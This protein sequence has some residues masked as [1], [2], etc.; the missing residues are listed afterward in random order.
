MSRGVSLRGGSGSRAL[1]AA[2]SAGLSDRE[3]DFEFG[4]ARKRAHAAGDGALQR[5]LRRFLLLAGLRFESFLGAFILVNE[6]TTPYDLFPLV[7][8]R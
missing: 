4:R 3:G 5:L 8:T 2:I 7:G 1:P 6:R